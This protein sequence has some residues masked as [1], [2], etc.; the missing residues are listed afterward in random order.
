MMFNT[1]QSFIIKDSLT[2]REQSTFLTDWGDSYNV[3]YTLIR[4]SLRT[5]KAI[6]R[7]RRELVQIWN[8]EF[9]TTH[10]LQLLSTRTCREGLLI[11]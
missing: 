6:L 8:I 1:K 5:S 4:G 7:S 9:T 2:D 10:L 3:R 11:C